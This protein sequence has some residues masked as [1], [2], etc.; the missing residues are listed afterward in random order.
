MLGSITIWYDDNQIL[1]Y[2]LLFPKYGGVRFK[3]NQ[4]Q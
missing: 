1:G 2:D 4:P 3:L